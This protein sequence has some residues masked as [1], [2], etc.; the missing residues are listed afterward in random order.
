M[1]FRY[2]TPVYFLFLDVNAGRTAYVEIKRTSPGNAE[3]PKAELVDP[4]RSVVRIEKIE[5]DDRERR[6]ISYE[7]ILRTNVSFLW[8]DRTRNF[9]DNKNERRQARLSS[10]LVEKDEGT[11]EGTPEGTVGE[12][13]EER[14]EETCCE[15][16]YDDVGPPPLFES[17]LSQVP[18]YIPFRFS[19]FLFL[20]FFVCFV[21]S[22]SSSQRPSSIV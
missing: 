6:R 11:F 1:T 20:F 8:S 5:R 4:C 16:P 13:F 18:R 3:E 12:T 9:L 19:Y 7:P 21:L 10:S 14:C 22:C 2:S 15:E 17:F